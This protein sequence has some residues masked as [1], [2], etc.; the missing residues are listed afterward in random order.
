MPQQFHP[1]L[2]EELLAMEKEDLGVREELLAK[3][4]LGEGYRP[5]MRKV[6]ERN[7]ARLKFIVE[8]HGWPGRTLVGEDGSHAAWRIVQHAIG[9]PGLQRFCVKAIEESVAIGEAPAAQLAFLVDRIRY[10]EGKPQIYGT[11]FHWDQSGRLSP[12]PI[13]DAEA[14]DER[15][16]KVG[17]NT[18]AQRTLEMR[19]QA[20]RENEAPAKN[21]AERDLNYVRWLRAVGW[22]S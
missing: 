7:A 9:D 8:E 16:R 2:R 22:R 3:G 11:Q 15:R 4:V 5:E 12:W 19:E 20:R 13:E 21:R 6:H 14:V 17:L 1:E 18:I 10:F